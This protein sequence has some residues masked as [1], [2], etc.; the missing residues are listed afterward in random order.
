MS[1]QS[2]YFG[3]LPQVTKYIILANVVVWLVDT[4]LSSRGIQLY[5]IGGLFKFGTPYFRLW[6]P[7]TYMFLHSGFWHLFCNMFA[8]LMFAPVLEQRWGSRRFLIYYLVCG[9]GAGLVQQAVW[10]LTGTPGVTVGA[11]GAVFGILFA[12][13]WLYPDV[14]MFLMFIPIP[15]KA[16]IFVFLYAA[17]ELWQGIAPGAGDNVAHFAHLGGMLFGWLLILY[18]NHKGYT[19]AGRAQMSS[20]SRLKTWWQNIKRRF[21]NHKRD[22]RS[23]FSGYHYQDPVADNSAETDNATTKATTGRTPQEEK[24]M[25]EILDKIKLHGYGS[26]TEYERSKLFR[27]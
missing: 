27:K 11:S 10:F 24:E 7:L 21:E 1:N 13:G 8:V 2:S 26:L 14:E 22:Q 17:F 12:F 9:I 4:I 20:D 3:S 6:Q 5:A 15:I 18:W 23:S 16:R 19:G 25:N